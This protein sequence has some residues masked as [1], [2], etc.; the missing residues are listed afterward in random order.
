MHGIER[1][2][3]VYL[4]TVFGIDL[5][6]TNEVV[7]VWLAGLVT[8]LLVFISSR[9][10]GVVARGLFQ[11]IFEALIEFIENRIAKEGIGREGIVWG[12]FLLTLFFFILFSNLLGVVPVPSHFKAATANINVTVGLALIVFFV[13]M[14]INIKRNGV[15]G[16]LKK[17]L[18][19][20]LPR[21]IAVIVVPIEVVSWLVRPVSLSIRLFANMVAGH[22]LIFVF[23]GLLAQAAWFLRVVPLAGAVAMSCFELFVCFIQA[24]IFTMLAGMYIREAV[25][26]GH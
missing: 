4:P 17:F 14:G 6:I 11:N 13:T 22:A 10:A 24:F 23:I 25:E 3:L 8:F 19:A 16:F 18:P 21:W 12:P 26:T 9:R 2:I 1:K 7:L 20:G 15:F 5:S